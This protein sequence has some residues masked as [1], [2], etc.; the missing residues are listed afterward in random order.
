MNELRDVMRFIEECEKLKSTFRFLIS[1]WARKESTADHSWRMVM[2]V[3]L[4]W[5]QLNMDIDLFHAVKIA[6]FHDVGEA[7]AWDLDAYDTATNKELKA[8]KQNDEKAAMQYFRD[9]LWWD[10]W[11]EVYWYWEEY[12]VWETKEAKFVKAVDKL[13]TLN[14]IVDA[15]ENIFNQPDFIVQYADK[16]VE[17]V[18]E[19]SEFL[20]LTKKKLKKAYEKW[21]FEWK[22]RYK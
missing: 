12:E 16:N 4:L 11:E 22:D 13:E 17:K 3:F 5:K 6:I 21:W 19:L 14:Q 20:E 10:L 15:W 1:S 8:K 2:M 9:L 18:P 7:I